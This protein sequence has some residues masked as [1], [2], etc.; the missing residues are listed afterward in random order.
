MYLS[1]VGKHR[2]IAVTK[3]AGAGVSGLLLTA[4]F[5]NLG[6]PLIA[7]FA[8]VP[9]MVCLR[10]SSSLSS[11]RWG[12]V[13]GMV[14]FLTLIY[15]LI[16]CLKTYGMIPLYLSLIILVL[17][18]AYLSIFIAGFAAAVNAA[19]RDAATLFFVA[20]AFWVAFEYLRAHLFTG[21]PWELLGY[22]QFT[23]LPIIQAAD[24]LGVY[25]VSFL[26]AMGNATV[27]LIFLFVSGRSWNGYMVDKKQIV[28]SAACFLAVFAGAWGYGVWRMD[29][30][31]TAMTAAPAKR[32]S[33]IQGNIGQQMKWD[34]AFQTATIDRYIALSRQEAQADPHLIV[35]PETAMPFYFGYDLPLTNRVLKG[36]QPIRTDTL[37]SS[38]GFVR[39]DNRVEYRNRAFML[40]AGRK[41]ASDIYDKAHLVPFG[42]YVPLKKWLPFLG[43]LVEQVGDF[44]GGEIGANLQWREHRI[45]ML[46][47]Y[48]LTF[49]YLSRAAA[50]NG[51]DLLINIT[52]DAWYGRTSAPFQ[53]FSMAVFRAVENRRAL[54][55]AANTG[56][57]GFV[58]PTGKIMAASPIFEE[59][60][61][62]AEI[63]LMRVSTLYS[64]FGDWFSLACVILSIIA[65]GHRIL[66]KKHARK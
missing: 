59:A 28:I 49:P 5:P 60:A 50:R 6:S 35:W 43:K 41:K 63:P 26:V 46:I 52:N 33:V 19:S 42:E 44:S 13:C 66:S 2:N 31:E 55:R 45:G 47:C 3:Y 64:R 17:F 36:I 57:S 4:S 8:L 38:P 11:L 9:L 34:P 53:H 15:W 37:I 48:E 39:T 18:A 58:A 30:I 25:G 32:V 51:A 65:L 14:H 12:Y 23:I 7:W 16:P 29:R 20:P 1:R 24:L 27:F 54:A 22:S 61:R 56:I 21:F 10:N 62:T 40:Q